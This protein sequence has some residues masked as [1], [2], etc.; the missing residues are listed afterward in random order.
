MVVRT[1]IPL[2]LNSRNNLQEL[3]HMR[4]DHYHDYHFYD[5]I[6]SH[7]FGID[8]QTYFMIIKAASESKPVIDRG[9]R[10]EGTDSCQ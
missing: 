10:S 8:L 1:I 2:L 7:F 3:R 5:D 6:P 9:E 4:S